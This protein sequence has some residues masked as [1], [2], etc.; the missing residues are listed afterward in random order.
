MLLRTYISFQ[1]F[2]TIGQNWFPR[3]IICP[4]FRSTHSSAGTVLLISVK[5]FSYNSNIYIYIYIYIYS[6]RR[7]NLKRILNR[8]RRGKKFT[9]ATE[10]RQS[11]N[12]FIKRISATS[13]KYS[14]Q[15]LMICCD[16]RPD[17]DSVWVETCSYIKWVSCLTDACSF[18]LYVC[19]Y[20][21]MY[22]CMYVCRYICTY[23]CMDVCKYVCTYVCM[24]EGFRKVSAHFEYLE[25]LLH[26]LDATWQPVRGDLTVHPWTVTLPWG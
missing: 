1:N 17:D 4:A 23:V 16:L 25:N 6:S 3:I 7:N 20:V 21:F 18:I 8:K 10:W 14:A 9:C 19:M 22:V 11:Y 26:G 2:S 15:S 5:D 12:I 13:L 24:Y